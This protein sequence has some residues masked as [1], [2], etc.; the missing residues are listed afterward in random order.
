[1]CDNNSKNMDYSSRI[2][3]PAVQLNPNVVNTINALSQLENA[4]PRGIPASYGSGESCYSGRAAFNNGAGVLTLSSTGTG[5]NVKMQSADDT[6]ESIN[7]SLGAAVFTVDQ[8]PDRAGL[9]LGGA[10]LLG[11]DV[12]RKFLLMFAIRAEF[13]QYDGGSTGQLANPLRFLTASPFGN[14]NTDSI[15]PSV[16]SNNMQQTAALVN[17]TKPGGFILA[18]NTA[19]QLLVNNTVTVKISLHNVQLIPLV[20]PF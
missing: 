9:A 12:L 1:M 16:F 15:T 4:P 17:L 11:I 10:A 18:G 14:V 3:G 8:L 2:P 5:A 20:K 7:G 13:I 6:V 19:L